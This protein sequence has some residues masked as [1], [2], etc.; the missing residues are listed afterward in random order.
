[1][2]IDDIGQLVNVLKISYYCGHGFLL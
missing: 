1:M 2:D